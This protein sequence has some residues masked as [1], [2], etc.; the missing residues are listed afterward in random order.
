MSVL[1]VGYRQNGQISHMLPPRPPLSLD[2]IYLCEAD[3]M[4]QFTAAGRF[5][6]FRH[7]L[8]AADL[9]IGELLAAHVQEANQAHRAAGDLDWSSRATQELITLLRDDYP[10]LMAVLGALSDID[11]VEV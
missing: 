10:T 6:Y 7:V 2:R 5:G 1:S 4:R 9:P 8:R 3:E 11:V